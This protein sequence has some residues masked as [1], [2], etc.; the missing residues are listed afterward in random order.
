MAVI[1]YRDPKTGAYRVIRCEIT[2][3]DKAG[4]IE[5]VLNEIGGVTPAEVY[6]GADEPTN[7]EVLWVDTDD[8]TEDGGFVLTEAELEEIAQMA[9]G[10]VDLSGYAK[11]EDVPTDDYI[12]GLIHTALGVIEN[13]TY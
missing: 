10:K 8:D 4:L 1:K 6:V 9:A 11:K 12:N 13:G 3:E 7:G 5:S 2:D